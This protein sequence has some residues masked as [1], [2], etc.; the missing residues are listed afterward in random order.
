M[1]LIIYMILNKLYKLHKLKQMVKWENWDDGMDLLLTV[2]GRP[3]GLVWLDFS[4]K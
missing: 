3:R 1:K 2:Q 4:Q